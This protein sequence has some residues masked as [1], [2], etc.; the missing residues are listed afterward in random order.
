MSRVKHATWTLER[1]Y[2]VPP[3][4]VFAAWADPEI[5][6]RWFVGPDGKENKHL[7]SDFRV[8]GRESTAGD[9]DGGSR[10]SYEAVYRDIVEDERIVTTYEMAIDGDRISV[11]VATVELLGEHTGP[12]LIY[13]EQGAYLDDLDQPE[14]RQQG[15]AGHLDRLGTELGRTAVDP[16]T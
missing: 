2:P 6:S 5:K 14:W 16:S 1:T 3:A 7:F 13:T 15:T 12:R 11:S 10:Y 9:A 4:R 8:G